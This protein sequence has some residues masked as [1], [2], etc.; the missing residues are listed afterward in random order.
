MKAILFGL[1][2][3]GN[4]ALR[5]LLAS[6]FEVGHVLT[7]D[8]EEA[9][10]HSGEEPLGEAASRAGCELI[11][12][13]DLGDRELRA[14]LKAYAADLLLVAS[15][16]EPLPASWF[17][18]PR[19]A[20]LGL[21]PSLL[22]AHRG[23]TPTA[24]MLIDDD[25]RSCGVTLYHLTPKPFVGDIVWQEPA[26]IGE[27][28]TDGTLRRRLATLSEQLIA[29]AAK[30]LAR[31][32][33]LPRAPQDEARIT[34]FPRRSRRDALIKFD[35]P[36]ANIRNRIRAM[37]PWPGAHTFDGE[38][39]LRINEL[40]QAADPPGDSDA[41]PGTVLE[42][43]GT[44]LLVRTRDRAIRLKTE[45]AIGAGELTERA[46]FLGEAQ[47]LDSSPAVSSQA[48]AEPHVRRESTLDPGRFPRM[49]VLAVAYPCNASC[50]NCPYTETNSEIRLKYADSPYVEKE[51]F[52]KIARECGEHGSMLRITGGGEPMMHPADMA[53]LIE[54]ARSVGAG[55]WLNTNG[56]LLP[57]EKQERLLKCNLDQ[58]EFS[59]DA[60]DP[61]TYRIVRAGLDWDNL[62]AT[63]R[64]MVKL[65]N[66]LGSTTNIVV[67]VINQAE[68]ADRLDEIV[69]FWLAQGVDEVIK[70]KFLT[71]GSN[72]ALDPASS[73]DPSPYLLK[74]AGEPC[75]YPFERLN[76]DSRGKVEVCGYDISGRT[77]FGNVREQ[78]IA[79]IWKG[80]QFEGWRAKH[81]ARRGSDIPLCRECPDWRYRSWTHNWK[82]VMKTAEGQRSLAIVKQDQAADETP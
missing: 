44:E 49:V 75:P 48:I 6:G 38:R 11:E 23:P 52:H 40:A 32:E 77:N 36:T 9:L 79:E 33:E 43:Q 31:G 57:L 54:Y 29:R 2:G 51:L 80:S 8:E 58:I 41:P 50:P 69:S 61:E 56:S 20:R 67:S 17:L 76:I 71:W 68:V 60:A 14:R 13:P 37:L 26:E 30:A 34:L 16:S 62:L 22:P 15:Y 21:H 27:E 42:Q 46:I 28:D 72:T 10:P 64:G 53:S 63:V 5:A 3:F 73:G 55:V 4:A 19:G 66:R 70:R 78:T 47:P 74:A 12:N 39:E 7:R 82:K 45:P 81:A 25:H 59:V 18:A 65:R 1:T 35:E 24:W